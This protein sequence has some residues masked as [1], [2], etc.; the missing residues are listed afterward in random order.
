MQKVL[1]FLT[2]VLEALLQRLSHLDGTYRGAQQWDVGWRRD[3]HLHAVAHAYFSSRPLF[4]GLFC[5]PAS[6][7]PYWGTGARSASTVAELGHPR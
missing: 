3:A 5:L 6:K 4:I 7:T 2:Q 1:A